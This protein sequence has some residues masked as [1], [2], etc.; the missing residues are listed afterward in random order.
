MWTCSKCGRIFSK[1]NQPHSCKKIPLEEHFTNKGKAKDLFD[2]LVALIN[3]E[4]GTTKTVSL[5]CCIHLFGVYDFLAALPKRDKL[6]VRFALDKELVKAKFCVP[7]STTTY[8][9]CFDIYS[10]EQFN[11]EFVGWLKESYHLKDKD[12]EYV[13][14]GS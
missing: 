5:P 2:F 10:K 6:E 7:L 11:H 4:I 8:K 13:V 3:K 1:E 12:K 9:N 14:A